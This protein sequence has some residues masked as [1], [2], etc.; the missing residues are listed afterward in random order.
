MV[1]GRILALSG[2]SVW[3]HQKVEA[4]V[5]IRRGTTM[6]FTVDG[7]RLISMRLLDRLQSLFLRLK[8]SRRQRKVSCT[9]TS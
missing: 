3:E 7:A 2:S 1:M 5:E 9:K 4:V 6:S 8:D